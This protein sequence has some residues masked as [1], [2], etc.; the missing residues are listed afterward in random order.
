VKFCRIA[1]HP[2]HIDEL[3]AALEPRGFT[4]DFIALEPLAGVVSSDAM[5]ENVR[6]FL[7]R[8]NVIGPKDLARLNLDALA[9]AP[10]VDHRSLA[11]FV[12]AL[13]KSERYPNAEVLQ[14]FLVRRGIFI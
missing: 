8:A 5:H 6:D 3:R 2:D 1:T 14:D 10:G 12:R 7:V 4:I 11:R 9:T 13:A